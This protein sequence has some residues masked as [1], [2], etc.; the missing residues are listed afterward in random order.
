MDIQIINY[1]P[2]YAVYFDRFN[3]DWLEEYFEV[4]PLDKWVLENP[5]EAIIN[6]KGKIFF[7]VYNEKL[8]GTV[9]LILIT[10]GVYELTK[11]AVEKRYQGLGAGKLLCLTAINQAR[12]M[13]AK[14]LI[15]YSQT[16]L[17]AAISIY[18]KLGFNEIPIEQG[19]Y[20][21]ANI[22]MQIEF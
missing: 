6:K 13:G 3:R 12:N 20:K 10:P 21:K 15:L 14:K 2:E 7:A 19:K 8:I 1:K 9:A 11:M 4:E 16:N 17:Q 5:E 22:K 18:F